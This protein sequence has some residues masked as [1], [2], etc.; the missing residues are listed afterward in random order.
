MKKGLLLRFACVIL[1]LI[2][3]VVCILLFSGVFKSNTLFING[4]GI[5]KENILILQ[6]K[7]ELPFVAILSSLGA[8]VEWINNDSAKIKYKGEKYI[9]DL[10]NK[11]FMR[12]DGHSI[13]YLNCPP[14]ST[15]YYCKVANREVF[16]D[17]STIRE[18]MYFM[19]ENIEVMVVQGTGM[20]YIT[21]YNNP[22]NNPYDGS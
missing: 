15:G 8:N 9:L 16:I 18:I 13:N 10:K 6:G 3:G 2:C 1:L 22:Y 5:Y 19:G 12:E 4:K 17:S 7:A 14:G 11:S 21:E 20:V